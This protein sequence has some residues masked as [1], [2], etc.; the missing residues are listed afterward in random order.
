MFNTTPKHAVELL[1]SVPKYNQNLMCLMEKICVLDM[2]CLGM[3]YSAV[4]DANESTCIL[5]KV[6]LN[7]ST[8]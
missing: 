3:N 7:R 5:N 1:S 8:Y 2:F 4:S 6:S